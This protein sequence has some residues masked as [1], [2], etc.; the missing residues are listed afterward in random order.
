MSI[1]DVLLAMIVVLFLLSTSAAMLLFLISLPTVV[2]EYRQQR[3]DEFYMA[4]R[5][6]A[7]V[8][9]TRHRDVR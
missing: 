2:K 3:E 8:K 7:Q 4:E 1:L 6:T 9:A 5:L